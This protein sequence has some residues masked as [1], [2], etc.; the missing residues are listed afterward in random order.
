MGYVS[1]FLCDGDRVFLTYSTTG[2]GIE[3][4]SGSLALP[5]MT[6]YGRGARTAGLRGTTRAGTGARTRPGTPPGVRPAA[7]VPQCTRLGATQPRPP[8][9]TVTTTEATSAG[10]TG[11]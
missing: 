8:A 10:P 11:P 7:L 4:G 5:D 1:C 9:G 3:A 6:P 2:R